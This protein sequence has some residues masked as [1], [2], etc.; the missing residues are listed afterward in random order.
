MIRLTDSYS[1]LSKFKQQ[2]GLQRATAP[3][4]SAYVLEQRLLKILQAI[5]K[6]NKQEIAAKACLSIIRLEDLIESK[7]YRL[8]CSTLSESLQVFASSGLVA[9]VC[10]L[11]QA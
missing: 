3:K 9:L 11:D 6:R 2:H 5:D 10:H 4:A 7:V 1:R 8:G